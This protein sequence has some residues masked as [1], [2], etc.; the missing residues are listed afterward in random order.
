MCQLEGDY[1]P[2]TL[3]HTLYKCPHAQRTI[4]YICNEFTLQIYIK[5]HEI[6]ISNAKCTSNLGEKPN[7]DQILN[8]CGILKITKTTLLP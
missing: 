8:E 5:V 6:I 2:A 1:E 7:G 4:Q 3:L